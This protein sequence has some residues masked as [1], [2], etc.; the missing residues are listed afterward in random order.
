V[1]LA[2]LFNKSN[3]PELEESGFREDAL[4]F[5][6]FESLFFD[7]SFLILLLAFLILSLNDSTCVDLFC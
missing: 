6:K 1:D 2:I 7:I 4:L 5:D 3:Q